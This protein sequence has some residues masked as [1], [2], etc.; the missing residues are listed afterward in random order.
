MHR[1]LVSTIKGWIYL[2][3]S[4]LNL[5]S[6]HFSSGEKTSQINF[7]MLLKGHSVFNMLYTFTNL[8]KHAFWFWTLSLGSIFGTERLLR[9]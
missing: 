5:T 8:F 1:K 6:C 9:I 7:L 4:S 3:I 2:Y